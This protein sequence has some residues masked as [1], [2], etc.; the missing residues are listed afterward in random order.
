[1]SRQM[2]T[3]D[4]NEAAARVAHK[5]SEVVAIYPIT[6]SSPMGEHS[7][8]WS[9]AGQKNI[10]GTVPLVQ[11]MQS[12]GGASATVH[13]ALQTGAL[14]TTFTASQGLLLMIPTMYKIAA[15]L[16]PTV[17][18]VA[19]RSLAAQ[20]LSIFGDHSDVM[21]VR[22]TGFG[23]LSSASIQEVTDLAAIAH[24]ATLKSRIPFVHFFDGFRTSHEIQKIEPLEDSVLRE[25]MDD[26][27]VFAHR[28]RGLNPNRPVVRGTSQNPDV[29][30]QG[31]E[32]V[33]PYYLAT[34]AIVQEYM[35]LFG[36]LTGRHYRLFDYVGAPDAEH[37]IILMGSGC[38]VAHETV[39]YLAAKGEKVGIIKV[40]LY[41]PFDASAFLS[42]IPES[43]K[44]IS[45]LDRTKEP[46]NDGEPMFK[47]VCTALRVAGRSRIKV[48]G[49]RFG[50]SSKE[51][52]PASVKGVFNNA[53]GKL[54]NDFT[55]GINDDVT[56]TNIEIPEFVLETKGLHQA[57]FLGLGSDGTVG[58]NKN[59][60][61]IIGGT[62]DNY[63]QGYFVYDSKKAGAL[64]VS[65][66][67]FGPDPIRR[68]CLIDQANFVACHQTVFVE[69]YDILKY[70]AKGATFLLNT[71]FSMDEIWDNL[72]RKVQKDMLE[73]EIKFFVID[74]YEVARN[75]G[76]GVM[77]N[78]IMQTCFFA[79]SGV[80]DKDEAIEKIKGAIEKSY[81]KKGQDVVQKN[82]I[83]VDQAV[84]NLYQ[85]NYPEEITSSITIPPVVPVEAPEF[86]Q[87][88][89]ATIMAQRGN[90]I[91][92]S[93]MPNDG[94]WPTATTQWEKR[95]IA[96]EIPVWDP[97]VCIQ[98]GLCNLVCPHAAIR[99]KYYDKAVLKNA[100][101]TFKS[102]DG[103]TKFKAYK[104][105]NQVAPEDC[106]GCGA[107]VHT[108]PARNKNT[109]GRKAIN[110]EPQSPLRHAEVENYK[111]FLEIPD[112]DRT[113]LNLA[114]VKESQLLRPLFEYSGA[115][116]GCG[117]TPYVKLLSQLFGDRAVIANATGCSSIYGGNLPTTPYAQDS[118]GRGP[119]WN[120]SLFED[121][122]EFGFGFRLTAD[123]HLET[124]AEILTSMSD[125]LDEN[126]IDSLLNSKNKTEL[127]IAQQRERVEYLKKALAQIDTP[128]ARQLESLV[129]YFVPRSVWVI[130][131]D[132]WAYDIGYG[133]LDHVLAQ[134]RNVNVLVVDTGVYSNT[135]GQ[136]SK[137]TPMG[138][139]AKF[140][141]AGKPMP[142]K[143]LAMISMTYGNIYVAQIAMGA[144][145]NQTVKAFNEAES[146]DGPSI[147]I[148][149]SHCIAHGI[150]MTRGMDEHKLAVNSGMW[151][152]F[153]FDPRKIEKGECPL[154]LDSRKPA[155]P[156]HKLAEAE[157]R[158]SS[159]MR[160]N[161]EHAEKLLAAAQINIDRRFHLYE[162][163]AKMNWT[164]GE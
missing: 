148:A 149:Y 14:T 10:W 69:K 27:L 123:K 98:C 86:V 18:H 87:N 22:N 141:A 158:W 118:T 91:P 132:G 53:Q 55:V 106:T 75:T 54:K 122:A 26:E 31:R 63:A 94:S 114:T 155:I 81:G 51:F 131:G 116:A 136:C 89:T 33:N 134:G 8:T 119:A 38:E 36:K 124:A 96:L 66:L 107:C 9:A 109:E 49:G 76:M 108:C 48:V 61:K 59:S 64:T 34:P 142:K 47:D 133:G 152:L 101:E 103:N 57:V 39:E 43:V 74:A 23:L 28:H 126:L 4:G 29:Y 6:P 163:M 129:D 56:H 120:N 65:H 113:E 100:P 154:Q 71:S 1:M 99:M 72:P 161:P 139:V 95:N 117:E 112:F 13:G 127:E 19:A 41:R 151:P 145:W 135:G 73:K 16:T 32:T 162:Q 42:A 105:T 68:T 137:A 79:I 164:G 102:T 78:T 21:A 7:D 138:A 17:F 82:F 80:L 35:D 146:F 115:C 60:I 40:R 104:Y 30:F 44:T 70:A 111:F 92:V 88:V 12:E 84:A 97:E 83:A 67:R 46:G 93:A 77:I 125:K 15:E 140:A 150:N 160:S 147:I 110:M 3:I 2:I 24:A 90:D 143:D 159:L 52:T 25:L 50:L 153:R 121:A 156:F 62:T 130:G 85:V 58:A 20:A 37:I 157:G 45:V 128:E 144:N 11:E 5:L